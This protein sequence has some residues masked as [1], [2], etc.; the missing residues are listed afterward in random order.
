MAA[1]T[2]Y[3]ALAVVRALK[4]RVL[5]CVA[6][7][8]GVVHL[9]GR[10]CRWIEDLERVAAALNMSLAWSVAT[11]TSNFDPVARCGGARMGI[12]GKAA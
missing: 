12:A 9:H 1:D 11:G 8:A 3:I 5:T 10:C 4:D 7:K 6:G 2:T